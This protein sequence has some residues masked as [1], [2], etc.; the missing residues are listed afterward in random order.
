M[1]KILFSLFVVLL[2]LVGCTKE[3]TSCQVGTI[4]QDTINGVP[5]RVY[6]P[7]QYAKRA[8][9]EVFP[10]LYL[11]HGMFGNEDDWAEQGHLLYWMDSLL[12]LGEVREMV[13]VMPDN[14]PRKPTY[15]E[16]RD[17]ATT[18][19]WENH[20]ADFM[21]EAEA[22][23]SISHDPDQRAIA[24][25]SMGGYHTMRVASVLNGQFGYVGMFS[26]AT[27]IHQAP[28]NTRLFWIGIGNE[29]FLY[30]SLLSY[31][32]WLDNNHIEYTYYES[33]GGHIW[34]NWEDYLC[35][36]LRTVSRLLP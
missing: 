21:A 18:G 10:V 19:H 9:K 29:D 30:E 8:G 23:Y 12:C 17:N 34:P 36:Y 1:R 31:R 14:C 28:T 32:Q 4:S 13:I 2:T 27:F 15:E 26:P 25:L 35:R 5:C 33:T 16:E 24:G 20:F 3:P 7:N 6:L 11:Q 22:K